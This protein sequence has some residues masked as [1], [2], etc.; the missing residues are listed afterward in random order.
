MQKLLFDILTLEIVWWW[1]SKE[2]YSKEFNDYYWHF[3]TGNCLVLQC[4]F[5]VLEQHEEKRI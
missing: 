3:D 4:E 5:C 2:I 1:T